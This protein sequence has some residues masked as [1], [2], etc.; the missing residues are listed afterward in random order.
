VTAE[1]LPSIPDTRAGARAQQPKLAAYRGAYRRVRD[2]PTYPAFRLAQRRFGECRWLV[3]EALPDPELAARSWAL[4]GVGFKVPG[5]FTD[6]DLRNLDET[7]RLSSSRRDEED[8]RMGG[9]LTELLHRLAFGQHAPPLDVDVDRES[10]AYDADQARVT[11]LRYARALDAAA[12]K[13]GVALTACLSN[14][15]KGSMH[16]DLRP[17]EGLWSPALPFA[18][19]LLAADLAREAG[20]PLL[21]DLPSEKAKRPEAVYLDNSLFNKFVGKKAGLWRLVGAA[22]KPGGERKVAV[23]LAKDDLPEVDYREP[24]P[25]PLEALAPYLAEA[26]RIVAER[27]EAERVAWREVVAAAGTIPRS[28]PSGSEPPPLSDDDRAFV[29]ATPALAELWEKADRTDRSKVDWQLCR[30]ANRAGADHARVLRL[31]L[32]VPGG[33]A[34]SRDLSYAISTL[35]NALTDL[36]TDEAGAERARRRLEDRPPPANV[37]DLDEASRRIRSEVEGYLARG[38]R[39]VAWHTGV[40]NRRRALKALPPL[41]IVAAPGLSKT[42]T[43]LQVLRE[44]AQRQVAYLTT[45]RRLVL[46]ARDLLEGSS[47]TPPRPVEY[48]LGAKARAEPGDGEEEACR[49]PEAMDSAVAAGHLSRWLCGEC[50]FSPENGGT[51]RAGALSSAERASSSPAAPQ[52]ASDFDLEQVTFA[53]TVDLVELAVDRVGRRGI[54]E[55]APAIVLD[56]F[57]PPVEQVRLSRDRLD[58]AAATLAA[59]RSVTGRAAYLPPEVATI[60]LPAVRLAAEAVRRLEDRTCETPE[61]ALDAAST[62]LAASATWRSDVSAAAEVAEIGEGGSAREQLV[63]ALRATELGGRLTVRAA[64]SISARNEAQREPGLAAADAL[65]VA[66]WLQHWFAS[67]SEA[68]LARRSGRRE[69]LLGAPNRKVLAVLRAPVLPILISATAHIPTIARLAELE[70]RPAPIV[71]DLTAREE[72]GTVENRFIYASRTN[73]RGM[74]GDEEPRWEIAGPLVAAVLEIAERVPWVRSLALMAYP[75][76]AKKLEEGAVEHEGLR[77]ALE[78]WKAAGKGLKAVYPYGP[79]TIGTDELADFDAFAQVGDATAN[80]D[81][82]HLEADVLGIDR[83]E[84]VDHC[85]AAESAQF[86]GRGGG[87]RRAGRPTLNVAF[88]SKPPG[89]W[90]QHEGQPGHATF[91]RLPRGRPPQGSALSKAEVEALVRAA[92]SRRA[93]AKAAGLSHVAVGKHVAGASVS[94]DAAEKYRKAAEGWKPNPLHHH[95]DVED[96]VTTSP[97]AP[98]PEQASAVAADSTDDRHLLLAQAV[99]ESEQ[100]DPAWEVVREI[101]RSMLAGRAS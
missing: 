31:L 67:T 75:S 13:R 7:L 23:D 60:A 33:K 49:I 50:L 46:R 8:A 52:D 56:E 101:A 26:E 16:L 74:E 42:T 76:I 85:E 12:R 93:L 57:P 28:K 4:A 35:A 51:C 77:R 87:Y 45:R 6:D 20:V 97:E 86:F 43:T 2:V 66:G 34:R 63:G 79:A 64:R 29:A 100:A 22:K 92:G 90:H 84:W 82:R 48:W 73:R 40:P 55:S 41:V 25:M 30:A 17:P 32:A 81:A 94:A 38:D 91:E 95:Q 65:I 39:V 10:P 89:G 96:S 78:R 53:A 9:R 98:R 5:D 88:A 24:A 54:G 3:V 27:G 68:V 59:A 19:G 70:G 11:A 21:S 71:L 14:R 1:S 83:Q 58:R 62:A 61:A 15:K 18:V 80:L 69:L 44:Q 99:L 72:E 36:R 37:V 47:S